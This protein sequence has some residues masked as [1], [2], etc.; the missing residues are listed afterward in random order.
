[1]EVRDIPLRAQVEGA[2]RTLRR[3]RDGLAGRGRIHSGAGT[4]AAEAERSGAEMPPGAVR[5]QPSLWPRGCPVP[6]P[7]LVVSEAVQLP[8]AHIAPP[9]H[10]RPALRRAGTEARRDGSD[11]RT[12][13]GGGGAGG[14]RRA[15]PRP[16]P[17]GWTCPRL[18]HPRRGCPRG[19]L[20]WE[21]TAPRGPRTLRRPPAKRVYFTPVM[22]SRYLG[23][24]RNHLQTVFLATSLLKMLYLP[25]TGGRTRP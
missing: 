14:G 12:D 8:A 21:R 24:S 18:R 1:M 10:R 5:P 11:G 2:L 9:P 4:Q 17:A 6:S 22:T 19:W 13:E 23:T 25:R 7:Y 16:R 20:P 3:R 15:A